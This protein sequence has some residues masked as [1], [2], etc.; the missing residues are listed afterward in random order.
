MSVKLMVLGILHDADETHGYTILQK[1]N[2][3]QAET[4]TSIKPGSV[5]HALGQLE[6]HHLAENTG[7]KQGG[8]PAATGYKITQAGK[9][10]LYGLI[11]K[12]LVSYDQEEFTAGLAWMHLLPRKKVV[13]LTKQ[14]LEAY[15]E[16]NAFMATL[17][18]ESIPKIPSE[19]PE[20]IGSWQAI[21]AATTTWQEGFLK[22]IE[23]GSHRFKD[24]Q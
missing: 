2:S 3:W 1:L 8:G 21:F 5:Y 7:S 9:Q 20:I 10:E 24:E 18:Q 15:Y 6:K 16:L 13:D 4:W 23:S 12:A 11:E 14:R 22:R 19:N 17:P